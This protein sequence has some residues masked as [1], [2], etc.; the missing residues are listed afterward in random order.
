MFENKK[1]VIDTEK[2]NVILE[3][4]KKVID[5]IKKGKINSD[6]A[7]ILD[8]LIN[9]KKLEYNQER[10]SF[11]S[12]KL[13]DDQ[14]RGVIDSITAEDFHLIIGPPGT[15][16]TYVIEELSKQF[17][18]RKQ[19]ILMTAWTN[20]AV[21]NIIKRLP[22]E[23]TKN[24]V[25]I[26]PITEVDPE[27][28][29]FSIFEKMN[30]H[31]DWK[32]VEKQR[33]IRDELFKL[34]PKA[35][36]EINLAQRSIDQSK[37]TTK[38]L[39]NELDNFTLEKKKYEELLSISIDNASITDT[40]S[41][42]NE[43]DK[44][45]EKSESCLLLSR[46]IL[47]MNN[48]QAKIP[49]PI[50]I[51]NLKK[52]TRNMK[53]FIFGKKVFSLFSK[54]NEEEL[55]SLEKEYGKNRKYLDETF[56]LE[57]KY[58]KL[59][60]STADEFSKIY[61][62]G[63]GFPDK[64][65]LNLEFKAYRTLEDKYFPVLK[66]QEISNTKI[67]TSKINQEVYAIYLDSLKKKVEL[68]DIKIKGINTEMYI[69]INHKDDLHKKYINLVFSL[70]FCKKNIDKLIKSIITDII[71]KADIIASTAVSSCHHFLDN[72]N[73]DVMIMDEASQVASFMSLLPLMKCKK[74]I[75]VYDISC[76]FNTGKYLSSKVL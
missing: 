51:K 3:R 52:S 45:N 10:F 69:Q 29:K 65:T 71:D 28:K 61:P 16:K 58:N 26:G 19:K 44:I 12:R 21:D 27:V 67:I 63:N 30:E 62:D 6:N 47:Q 15:G 2:T 60:K 9:N 38:I 74:F 42:I 55:K 4:L 49:D 37:N 59:K 43:L 34:I 70:D 23:E 33:K 35:K 50:Y 68:L 46:N 32:E 14:K 39:N 75:L 13:N 76:S 5:K 18:K 57:K 56:E 8:I 24:I 73:F 22:K 11:I 64:D 1:V 40:S 17:V 25:R 36:E 54:K 31:K 53:L 48:L 7:R 72:T 66:E 41:I 20:L